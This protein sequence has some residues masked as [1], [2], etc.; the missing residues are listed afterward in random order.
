MKIMKI[1]CKK[2]NDEDWTGGRTMRT[3]DSTLSCWQMS[4]LKLHNLQNDHLN[5]RPNLDLNVTN[6]RWSSRDNA[7]PAVRSSLD[8]FR[9]R[10][11]GSSSIITYINDLG[12]ICQPRVRI[13]RIL[14]K[15]TYFSC[16]AVTWKGLCDDR[17]RVDVH[18]RF[19]PQRWRNPQERKRV[20][21]RYG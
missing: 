19:Q 12:Q 11:K 7:F 1:I 2:E 4:I 6:I 3:S 13:S 21:E 14:E 9:W 17:K 5:R 16:G 10:E 18:D 8:R 20:M 15:E